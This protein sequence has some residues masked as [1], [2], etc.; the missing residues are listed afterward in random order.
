M[1]SKKGRP[2]TIDEYISKCPEN[3]QPILS[4]IRSVINE[5]APDALEKIS[6]QMPSFYLKGTLV[7]FGAHKN[8]IGFYPM[9]SGIEA[10]KEEL[11]A[12]KYSKGAV[13]FPLDEPIPFD[14]IR[15]IVK[16]RVAENLKKG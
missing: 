2:S 3:V 11:S 5:S 7:W 15:R 16:F 14:L 4:E 1:E 6:Y 10:F 12:Y 8:H 9:G 13:Q